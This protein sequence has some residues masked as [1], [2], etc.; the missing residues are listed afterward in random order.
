MQQDIGP[1]SSRLKRYSANDNCARAASGANGPTYPCEDTFKD[2]KN[3]A[4]P[5]KLR[6]VPGN[7]PFALTDR[8]YSETTLRRWC[9]GRRHHCINENGLVPTSLEGL[10][11][12][13]AGYLSLRTGTHYRPATE[14]EL[15]QA[16]RY[17][18]GPSNNKRSGISFV[19]EIAMPTK[20]E[21][22]T[23]FELWWR[24]HHRPE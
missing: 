5:G 19:R 17:G 12:A 20:Q 24:K 3:S 14:S 22:A 10:A 16:A 7:V 8:Q 1:L 18:V 13:Y 6:V 15:R 2:S 21:E 9:D 11:A 4:G 23:A